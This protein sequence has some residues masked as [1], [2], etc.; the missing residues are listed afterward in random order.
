VMNQG[1]RLLSCAAARP[2]RRG[3]GRAVDCAGFTL[4][5]VLVGIAIMAIGVALALSLV[6]GSLGNIRKVQLRT[7]SIE[8]AESVMESALLDPSIQQPTAFTGNFEDGTRW[9]VRVED[10]EIPDLQQQPNRP[11]QSMPVKLL[12]FSVEVIGPESITSD[13][14]LQTLKLV[15]AQPEEQQPMRMPQ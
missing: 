15:K 8:H 1:V 12:S 9:S 7:R 5:E 6:A 4:L 14:H 11:L 13:Y 3:C 2:V 10:Y